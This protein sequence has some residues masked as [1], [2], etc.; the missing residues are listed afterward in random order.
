MKKK[1]IFTSIA[2][3]ALAA[4][5]NSANALTIVTDA[6]TPQDASSVTE[7]MTSNGVAP[8]LVGL[9]VT[10]AFGSSSQTLAWA[11]SVAG[12]VCE[13]NTGSTTTGGVIGAGW[14]LCGT[15]NTFAMLWRFTSSATITSLSF[16][17]IPSLIAFDRTNPSPGTAGSQSGIDFRPDTN[18][19]GFADDPAWTVTYSNEIGLNGAAALGDLYG[20]LSIDFGSD[21]FSGAFTYLQDTDPFV[22]GTTGGGGNG[23]TVPEPAS[24]ALLALGLAG[25]GFS[26]RKKA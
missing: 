3:L 2:T 13:A 12:D 23:G 26:R 19:D 10:A 24:I 6:G 1:V 25:L 16:A 11:P 4:S 22:A 9:S 17:G 14:S 15:G 20:S 7:F 5:V 18:N 21:G 8:T